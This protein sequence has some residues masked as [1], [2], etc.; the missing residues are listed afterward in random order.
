MIQHMGIGKLL[1]LGFE[2]VSLLGIVF[3]M[4]PLYVFL[5][6]YYEY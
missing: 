5:T 6:L 2:Y 3:C 4:A 1:S